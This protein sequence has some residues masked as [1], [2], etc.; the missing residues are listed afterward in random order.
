LK[1]FRADIS[2]RREWHLLS[3]ALVDGQVVEG[4]G[5]VVVKDSGAPASM[6]CPLLDGFSYCVGLAK[7][8]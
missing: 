8:R 7:L 2:E 6:V 3:T 1:G 4:E 5:R